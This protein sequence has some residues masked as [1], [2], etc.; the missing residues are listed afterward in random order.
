[1]NVKI[2]H[3]DNHIIIAEKPSRIPVGSDAS[4]DTTFL[5][6][7]RDYFF[8]K[9]LEDGNSGKGYCVPIHFLDRPVSGVMVFAVSSKAAKRINQLFRE[10]RVGKKYTAIVEGVPQ[11]TKAV[12]TDFLCKNR[13][14]NKSWVCDDANPESKECQLGYQLLRTNGQ[15]SALEVNPRTGRSH[16]IRA[17]L[18]HLGHPIVGDLKYGAGF[19]WQGRIALHSHSLSFQHP[20]TREK[21]LFESKPPQVFEEL[22]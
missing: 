18:A 8:K 16:Q 11:R 13:Q 17:Q 14:T 10:R 7:I 6:V 20:V 22:L 2:L 5:Q 3:E 21:V 19:E 9:R 1:M 4:R 15:F 12:L